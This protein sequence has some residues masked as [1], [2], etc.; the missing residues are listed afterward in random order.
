M[1]PV[2]GSGDRA[3]GLGTCAR[4]ENP[5]IVRC[6]LE[7]R[8]ACKLDGGRGAGSGATEPTRESPKTRADLAATPATNARRATVE[9]TPQASVGSPARNERV[10]RGGDNNKRAENE[11]TLFAAQTTW[12]RRAG[13]TRAGAAARTAEPATRARAESTT[14]VE[15]IADIVVPNRRIGRLGVQFTS[16]RCG[17]D[18]T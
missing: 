18:S 15:V 14:G 16:R 17:V 7:R 4:G 12:T 11:R 3:R 2:G 8:G 5:N 6:W 13:A 1:D 10:R 9:P